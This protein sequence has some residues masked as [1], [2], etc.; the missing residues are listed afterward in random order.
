MGD[1]IQRALVD[2]GHRVRVYTP[3]GAILPGM[4]Y[5]VRRLLENTSNESFLKASVAETAQIED[6]LRDPEEIGAML[7]RTRR[8][9]TEPRPAAGATELQPFQ[10][11]AADRFARAEN[12][13][14]MRRALDEVRIQLGQRYPLLIGGKE[15][16]T[17]SRRARFGQPRARARGSSGRRRWPS[18]E[19]RPPAV[20][21][22]RAAFPAWA[23]TP[24]ADR[25]AILI[26]AAAIMRKRRFELAAWEIYECGKPWA[27]ADADVAEAIDFCE[28]YAREMIRLAEPRQP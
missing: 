1:S 24:A 9:K 18:V 10:Q 7:T 8:P 15:V 22:A 28:F 20:A 26:K 25:A 11:R 19:M 3:Y 4:A 21:A 12:R 23:A 13:E 2:R 27:E 14:A 16:D 17:G 6:L 5:L